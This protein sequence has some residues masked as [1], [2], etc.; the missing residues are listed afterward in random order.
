MQSY[1]LVASWLAASQFLGGEMTVEIILN[2]TRPFFVKELDV[3]KE[4][5]S[6]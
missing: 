3:S 5:T 1:F 6:K 4:F 2:I